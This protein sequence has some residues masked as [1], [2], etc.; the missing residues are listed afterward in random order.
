M[1]ESIMEPEIKYQATAVI[2]IIMIA[3]RYSYNTN[4]AYAVII[5]WAM[6]TKLTRFFGIL[7][8]A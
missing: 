7:P 2:R 8:H 5:S 1:M 6:L 3:H 4:P